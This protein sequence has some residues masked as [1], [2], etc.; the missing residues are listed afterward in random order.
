[1]SASTLWRVPP[2]PGHAWQDCESK[3]C[4]QCRRPRSRQPKLNPPLELTAFRRTFRLSR[5]SRS[6]GTFG[7]GES[8]SWPQFSFIVLSKIPKVASPV[9][10]AFETT[11]TILAGDDTA[12]AWRSDAFNRCRSTTERTRQERTSRRIRRRGSWFFVHGFIPARMD[13]DR[14]ATIRL[15]FTVGKLNCFCTIHLAGLLCGVGLF[16]QVRQGAPVS[17]WLRASTVTL[18]VKTEM[19]VYFILPECND[20]VVIDALV[21][22]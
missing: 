11:S 8:L 18:I 6:S 10:I 12:C 19:I 1:M 21:V 20:A 17:C 7:M 3:S 15:N 14:S 16:W 4:R 2:F 5:T 13:F 9:L 22:G